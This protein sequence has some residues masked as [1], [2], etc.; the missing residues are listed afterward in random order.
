MLCRKAWCISASITKVFKHDQ[1]RY[2]CSGGCYSHAGAIDGF[3]ELILSSQLVA[4]LARLVVASSTGTSSTVPYNEVPFVL[5]KFFARR[6]APFYFVLSRP[7]ACYVL[8][9]VSVRL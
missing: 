2:Y 9:E 6:G 3:D 8:I 1:E 4:L 5:K 7:Y